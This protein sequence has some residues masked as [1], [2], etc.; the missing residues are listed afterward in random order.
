MEF[1]AIKLTSGSKSAAGGVAVIL[2]QDAIDIE[3]A[4]QLDCVYHMVVPT[5]QELTLSFEYIESVSL[6]PLLS[7]RWRRLF[8]FSFFSFFITEP[9]VPNLGGDIL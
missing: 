4:S 6:D 7:V 5:E 1:E 3:S 2:L 9:M 8:F